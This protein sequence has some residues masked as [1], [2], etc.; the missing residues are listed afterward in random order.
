M[1]G[2]VQASYLDEKKI[3]LLHASYLKAKPYS[4]LEL[5]GFFKEKKAQAILKALLTLR[6]YDK[7]ADLFHFYQTND[8][9][10]IPNKTLQ[11]FRSFLASSEFLKYMNHLTGLKF[12]KN[13]IDLAGSLY[14]NTNYLLCHDDQLEGRSIAFLLYLNT[15][16]PKDG[17]SLNLLDKK[18][19]VVK[20]L[21]P[22]F[23]TF[24]FFHVSPISF[25][26][27]EEIV[28]DTQRIALG[29]WLHD[30]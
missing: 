27:V 23:N 5:P 3:A 6:F 21:Y 20:K 25:H 14:K 9:A 22:K 11:D 10:S 24:T 1:D 26:E 19:K 12:K 8:I 28:S 16:L 7:E 15:L 13:A 2:W 17:G 4:Y 18:Q 30:P 29:G